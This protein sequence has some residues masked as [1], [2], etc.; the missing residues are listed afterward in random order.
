ME[1]NPYLVHYYN[2]NQRFLQKHLGEKEM[3]H[4]IKK[5][6]TMEKAEIEWICIDD[7]QRRKKIFRPFYQEM[8]D[9]ICSQREKIEGFIR[10]TLT[11]KTGN[12]RLLGRNKTRRRRR[13]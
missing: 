7:L 4:I 6:K 10:G 13:Y 5:Y 9:L 12:V 2:N 11:G 1:Y 8:I 3:L